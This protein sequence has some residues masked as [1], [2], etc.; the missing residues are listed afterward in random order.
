MNPDRISLLR[1]ASQQLINPEF[2][3]PHGIVSWM[4]AM[5]AQDYPM[6]KWAIG[7]RLPGITDG[8]VES[9]IARGEILR[10]HLLRPTWHFVAPQD[11]YWLLDLTAP[12]IKAGQS[13]RDRQLELTEAVYS[14]SNR[15]IERALRSR[16]QLTRE[17]L[18]I[19]LNNVGIATDQN[20]AS[21]LLMRAELEK[22]ICS[23]AYLRGKPT[24]ALLAEKVPKPRKLSREESLAELARRYFTSRSPATLQDFTWWSG[25]KAGDARRALDSVK[26]EFTAEAINGHDHWLSRDISL[27]QPIQPTV[28][29]LPVL[30]EFIVSYADRSATIPATLEKHMKEISDNGVFRPIIV[31]NGTVIGIWKRTVKKDKLLVELTYFT[32][33]NEVIIQ[34]VAEAANRF[35]FFLGKKVEVSKISG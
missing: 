32:K 1:L 5:Q 31:V 6:A 9:A 18:I 13:S 4:G 30:D 3:A 15:T 23:S 34:L 8:G 14:R 21:H 22:I 27:P 16:G 29:I 12:Q 26:S 10:T 17:D 11:I 24:Y 2:T 33:P 7:V 28:H 20:R 25:L 35:G 19:E